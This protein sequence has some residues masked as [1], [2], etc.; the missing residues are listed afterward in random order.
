MWYLTEEERKAIVHIQAAKYLNKDVGMIPSA[1]ELQGRL[2]HFARSYPNSRTARALKSKEVSLEALA[3]AIQQTCGHASVDKQN[4][5][6]NNWG[7]E[8]QAWYL[9]TW[10]E[11]RM[12]HFNNGNGNAQL[13]TMTVL[14]ISAEYIRKIEVLC[15]KLEKLGMVVNTVHGKRCIA[16]RAPCRPELAAA[17]EIPAVVTFVK[18]EEVLKWW[19]GETEKKI[20]GKV[21]KAADPRTEAEHAFKVRVRQDRNK[22]VSYL[23]EITHLLKMNGM[24]AAQV[25]EIYRQGLLQ[26]G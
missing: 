24:N 7:E 20:D 2:Q 11:D 10:K 5:C 26:Q 12:E 17:D 3:S 19:M 15:K 21:L 9:Q 23:A 1:G 6:L 14:G 18:N 16:W 22:T 4:E 13:V 25:A 8:E